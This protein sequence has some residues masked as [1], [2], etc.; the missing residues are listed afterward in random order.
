[1]LVGDLIFFEEV[2]HFLGHHGT[3]IL[4]GDQ[5]EF[6]SHLGL[7]F[8]RHVVS[9]FRLVG[10]SF[11]IHQWRVRRRYSNASS[12]DFSGNCRLQP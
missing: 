12:E 3:I 4:D 6:F 2:R 8:K 10:H 11:S 1:M 7:L 5:R 9:L